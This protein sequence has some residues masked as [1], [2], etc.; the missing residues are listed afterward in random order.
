MTQRE[1]KCKESK[2]IYQKLQVLK[3]VRKLEFNRC[4]HTEINQLS[5]CSV[6]I[7][8]EMKYDGMMILIYAKDIIPCTETDLEI[9][10]KEK[11]FIFEFEEFSFIGIFETGEGEEPL[12]F[13]DV[14]IVLD[15]I[16]HQ[17]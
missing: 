13:D 8:E 17:F 5:S 15:L 1:T 2:D 12:T 9:T 4:T 10:D 16:P 3:K 7:L 14:G 11:C 6:S